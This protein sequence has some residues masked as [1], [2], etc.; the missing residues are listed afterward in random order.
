MT[1]DT[2][3]TEGCATH[4]TQACDQTCSY[5]GPQVN[6]GF[7]D[8]PTGSDSNP[9][10]IEYRVGPFVYVDPIWDPIPLTSG[11]GGYVP[12]TPAMPYRS[13]ASGS[14]AGYMPPTGASAQPTWDEQ[15]WICQHIGK[16][17][18]PCGFPNSI[19]YNPIMCGVCE[20]LRPVAP[21]AETPPMPSNVDPLDP[22]TS[23]MGTRPGRR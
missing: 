22:V 10:C 9:C 5:Q 12:P 20:A 6:D 19:Q 15:E 1:H 13:H 17:G 7:W 14:A 11:G 8:G 21:V 23:H 4:D 18:S 2:Q 16:N 3:G